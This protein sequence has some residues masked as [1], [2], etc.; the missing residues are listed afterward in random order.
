MSLR[1][2]GV[3]SQD[4]LAGCL[5]RGSTGERSHVYRMAPCAGTRAAKQATCPRVP[6]NRPAALPGC[7]LD[8][9]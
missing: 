6:N 1:V 2:T 5:G 8:A 3:M 7:A 9:I 4:W